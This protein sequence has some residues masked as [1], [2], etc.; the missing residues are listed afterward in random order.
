MCLSIVRNLPQIPAKPESRPDGQR[1]ETT[2]IFAVDRR[3]SLAI[4]SAKA[5]TLEPWDLAVLSQ[6]RGRLQRLEAANSSASTMVFLATLK[7]VSG[8]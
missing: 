3:V 8:E 1:D 7:L 2:L 6:G 5:V 4:N